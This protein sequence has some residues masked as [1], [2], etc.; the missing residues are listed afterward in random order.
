MDTIMITGSIVA[1]ITP[2]LTDGSV[3]YASLK[4]LVEYHIEQGTDGIVAVGTTGECATLSVEEH[5]NTVS[6]IIDY[7]GDR[8]P[9]IAGTG[10]NATHEAIALS[11]RAKAA[12][13]KYALSVA[14]Y[15]NRPNQEGLYQ[16]FRKVVESVDLPTILYNVPSRTCSDIHDETVLRLAELEN[17]IGIKDATGNMLRAANITHHAPEGFAL[18]SGDDNSALAY[19]LQGGHGVISVTANVAPKAMHDLC[20]AALAG[21]IAEA[22]QINDRLQALHRDLFVEPSPAP[23]KWAAHAMGLIPHNILRLPLISMSEESEPVMRKALQ[24]AGISL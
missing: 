8:V 22:R 2:M 12:G 13:A 1:I 7:A 16:H 23:T 4:K 9:V 14:P 20:V 17:I 18:Y 24:A 5:I 19:I 10:A 3:D 15:Y 11:K 6:A 21:N